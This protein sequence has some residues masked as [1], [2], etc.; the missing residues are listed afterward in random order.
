[1]KRLKL[2]VRKRS[3]DLVPVRFDEIT[4]RLNTLC[5]MSPPLDNEINP[6]EITQMVIERIKDG[7]TTNEIDNFISL[8]KR[9]PEIIKLN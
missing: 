8:K 1:M 6:F 7:I 4:D 2:Y 3:G 9:L 5:D